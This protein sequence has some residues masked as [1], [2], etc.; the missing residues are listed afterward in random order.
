MNP[1]EVANKGMNMLLQGHVQQAAVISEQLLVDAADVAPVHYFACEVA[2]AKRQPNDALLHISRAV[3]LDEKELAL[4][5]KKAQIEVLCREGLKAQETAA[6]AAALDV[7]NVP[8]QIEAARLFIEC[9]NHRGAE[10]FLKQ[11][12]KTQPNNPSVLFEYAK[13]QFYLGH[14]KAA[15]KAISHFLEQ[16][17]PAKGQMYLLQARLKK[18][19]PKRNH[20]ETLKDY[21]SEDRPQADEVTG[22]FALAKELED[23]GEFS[24]SFT[25]LKTGADKQRQLLKFDL[26]SELKNLDD[27]QASLPADVFARIP[28]TKS[29]AAPIFIIG[30]PRTGATLVEAMLTRHQNVKSIGESNDFSVAMAKVINTYIAD[31]PDQNLTPLSAA[32]HVDYN[33]IADRYLSSLASM[34]GQADRYV[35]KLPYNFLYCGLIKKAFPKARIIHMVRDPM[36]TCYAIYKTL[37]HQSYFFS[38][39]LDELADYYSAY[40]RLMAHWHDLMPGDILDVR[41]ESLVS[42]P[43]TVSK[44]II[45]YCG[46]DWTEDLLDAGSESKPSSTAGA[47]QARQPINTSSVEKW[48]NFETELAPVFEKLKDQGLLT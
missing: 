33:E 32:Q 19:T 3:E 21:L 42:D 47:K 41:Y 14:M 26:T 46:L 40:R 44:K 35:N 48:R 6:Q 29:K 12:L 17:T 45:K 5:F 38:Y 8:A 1:I 10:A 7:N 11:A 24:D 2:L 20:V 28:A 18:Q 27:I 30:M 23:L 39:D 4:L 13:N 22:Y 34:L 9:E 16:E 36:D 37:F 25:A 15:N 43:T 31:H